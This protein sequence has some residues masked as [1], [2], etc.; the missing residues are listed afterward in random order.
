MNVT[1]RNGMIML[2]DTEKVVRSILKANV[3][4]PEEEL[5]RHMASYIADEVLLSSAVKQKSSPRMTCVSMFTPSSV[6]WGF[7]KLPNNT[8]CM[9]KRRNNPPLERFQ[10]GLP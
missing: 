3:D 1:K 2:Y 8:L 10:A 5:S 9:R 4:T 6:R 7:R